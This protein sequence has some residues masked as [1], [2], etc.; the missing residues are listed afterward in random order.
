MANYLHIAEPNKFS[1]PLCK[2]VND[3]LKL[4][5]HTFLFITD[6][7]D[8]SKFSYIN[9]YS[10][11]SRFRNY[12]FSNTILFYRLCKNSDIIYLH[13]VH[14][15]FLFLI[16]PQFIKKVAWVI[17]GADL[18]SMISK[19][20]R[21]FP[22]LDR[23]LLKHVRRY[24]SHIEGDAILA[25]K[26]FKNDA[27]YHYATMYLSNAVNTDNFSPRKLSAKVKIL[28]GNSNSKN[29]N[30]NYIFEKLKPFES[31]IEYILCPLS[32][33]NDI[34][35]RTT[36]IEQGTEI[37]GEKFRYLNDFISI[38][39]Y[40]SILCDIDIAVFNHWRQEA[41]GVTLSLLSLGK[42]V[43]INPQTTTYES[44]TKRGF[45]IFDNNELFNN[46]PTVNRA[47][48]K[49]KELIEKYYS[50]EV[51]VNTMEILKSESHIK[52]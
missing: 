29:N 44:F 37:F 20:N 39:K 32:Y 38:E 12:F 47:V 2:F 43:Y 13:G 8:K 49:N 45:Q 22:D 4:N 6:D 5:N 34:E 48:T 35:Y 42:I 10:F 9:V 18:Y 50:M 3:D 24:V 19:S 26:I 52:A 40:N 25:N 46:G 11:L 28:V 31:D 51:Q 7:F 30:H 23:F 1:L 27:S 21:S 15:S 16:F 36:V 33:G 41:L 14:F 17:M